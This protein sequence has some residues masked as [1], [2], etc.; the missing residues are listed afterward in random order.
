VNTE[1][2]QMIA[3]IERM[4]AAVGEN[5]QEVL[6]EVLCQDF[7]AFENGVHMAGRE[8][9]DLMSKV[10]AEGKRYRWSVNSPQV[11][12]Q[13]SLGAVVYV[14]HGSVVEQAGSDP[15]PL[16]W[17]E[18]VLLRREQTGWRIAFVHST[19]IKL[20]QGESAGG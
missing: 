11:E 4:Y 19:R 18:T 1:A 13:G 20:T 9:L 10:Y 7:H 17:L 3:A 14:N 6:N 2:Q 16:S 15:I 5:D 12:M 8:L